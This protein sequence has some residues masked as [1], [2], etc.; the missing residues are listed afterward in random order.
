MGFGGG[1]DKNGVGR[2]FLQGFQ[3]GVK[4]VLSETVYFIDNE[5]FI[6]T[7]GGEIFNIFPEFPNLVDAAITGAVD[8][9][10][11]KAMSLGN[12]QAGLAL[13]ARRRRGTVD[14][15]QGLGQD[16]GHRGLADPPGPAKEI[17]MGHPSQFQGIFQGTGDMFLP[18]N[19]VEILGSPFPG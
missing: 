19:F 3:E 16:A 12:L 11:I 18:H 17:G 6:A 7:Q 4:G 1:H 5:N 14:T 13:V 9:Q 2:R 8:L 10:D 15:V